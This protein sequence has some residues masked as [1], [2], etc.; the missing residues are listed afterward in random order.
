MRGSSKPK[1]FSRITV[2]R[3]TQTIR[4]TSKI[5]TIIRDD[6]AQ[7]PGGIKSR[8]SVNKSLDKSA[9]SDEEKKGNGQDGLAYKDMKALYYYSGTLIYFGLTILGSCVIPDVDIVF[10]FIGT[11]C[12][13]ALTFIFPT[14]FYL[15]AKRKFKDRIPILNKFIDDE[16]SSGMRRS[17]CWS[18]LDD[19]KF[20]T[21]CCY[22]NFS[23]GC[24]A[25]VAGM[26]N[27]I[28]GIID[29]E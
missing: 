2:V 7:H 3:E 24:V 11:I 6:D 17:N 29:E 4:Q 8:Q 9:C 15:M 21:I 10:E 14:M 16:Q 18:F 1:R 26:T 25:F 23:I 28:Y 13:N 22:I 19:E 12:V 27:N 5:F 20:L